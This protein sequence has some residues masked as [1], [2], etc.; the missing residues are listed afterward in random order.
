MDQ[1]ERRA[2]WDERHRERAVEDAKANP[3]LIEIAADGV[4]GRAL[5]VACG[6]GAN[7]VHLAERGWRVTAV[8]WSAVALEQGRAR[9]RDAGVEVTWIEADLLAWTPPPVAFD[10]VT[11]LF[12]HLPPAER[13]AVYG[14]AA[15]A[16][17]PGGRLLVVGHDRT[18]LTDGVG[19]PQDPDVLFT[20]RELAREL[21]SGQ[22]DLV[23]DRAETVPRGSSA[24]GIHRSVEEPS[25]RSPID[26][27]LLA[28][29][30]AVP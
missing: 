9:V 20:A 11:I 24:T 8:D 15:R 27:V 30:R 3:I 23:V 17:A 2:R 28:H 4:P 18:N 7:A 12:L 29:R 6:A 22:P 5:E 10:L 13:R 21:V 26:A 19:G 14:R 25:D 16:L 1:A